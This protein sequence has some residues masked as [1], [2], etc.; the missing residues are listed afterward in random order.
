[1]LGWSQKKPNLGLV[2]ILEL[3]PSWAFFLFHLSFPWHREKLGQ[4]KEEKIDL[5]LDSKFGTRPK[6]NIFFCFIRA[7][8]GTKR[9]SNGAKKEESSFSST[10]IS[11]LNYNSN[12]FPKNGAKPSL[13]PFF[14]PFFGGFC[15]HPIIRVQV[16]IR[17]QVFLSSSPNLNSNFSIDENLKTKQGWSS[18]FLP[19]TCC[20]PLEVC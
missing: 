15:H 6:V 3:C 5:K 14:S 18:K 11:K 2:P 12:F 17:A 8:L 1:M 19:R 20:S 4:N 7:F 10:P 9:N 16:Q 13:A